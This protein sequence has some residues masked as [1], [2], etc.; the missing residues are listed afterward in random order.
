MTDNQQFILRHLQKLGN[1]LDSFI[2]LHQ[3][4][5]GPLVS[6][7]INDMSKRLWAIRESVSQAVREGD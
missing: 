4:V 7:T 6:K 3:E 5:L 1:D 2:A